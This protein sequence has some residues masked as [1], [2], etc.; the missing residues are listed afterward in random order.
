MPARDSADIDDALLA[1]LNA[2]ATLRALMPGGVYWDPPPPN[3]RQVVVVSLVESY[4]QPMFGGRA[5]EQILYAV[6]AVELS[7]VSVQNGEAAAARIDELLDP[8]APA[9]PLALTI[10][11]YALKHSA[12]EG[13]RIRLTEEDERNASLRFEHRGAHY[14]LWVTPRAMTATRREFTYGR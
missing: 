9:P 12:R 1:F 5:F 2:D 11:G 3:S 13:T 6:K 7:T 10:P 14:R 4:D 8:Q